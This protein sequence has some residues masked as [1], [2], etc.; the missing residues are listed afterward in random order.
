MWISHLSDVVF[1]SKEHG[2]RA[3]VRCEILV[4]PQRLTTYLN[5]IFTHLFDLTFELAPLSLS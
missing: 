1:L 4:Q 5:N 2:I 3:L